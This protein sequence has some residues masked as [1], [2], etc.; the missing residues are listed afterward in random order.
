L[1][2]FEARARRSSASILCGLAANAS[3]M[4]P[5][6]QMAGLGRLAACFHGEHGDAGDTRHRLRHPLRFRP[7]PAHDHSR[8][9]AGSTNIPNEWL[10]YGNPWEIPAARGGVSGSVRRPGRSCRRPGRRRDPGATPGRPTENRAGRWPMTPRSWVWA[11][12]TRQRRCGCGRPPAG[13]GPT[14]AQAR[15]LQHRRL[16]RRGCRGKPAA[17]NLSANSSIRTTRVPRAASGVRLAAGIFSFVS[18][19]LAGI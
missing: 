17:D 7:V 1:P 10:S 3:R 11:R 8:A 16:S 19:S 4:P 15:R 2:V 5:L 9:R 18:A 6:G 13:S 14:P 12:A